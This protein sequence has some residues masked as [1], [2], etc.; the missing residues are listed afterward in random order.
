MTPI[1]T[2]ATVNLEKFPERLR[3]QGASGGLRHRLD[4]YTT[5]LSVC[6]REKLRWLASAVR[7]F[8]AF[9]RIEA[10]WLRRSK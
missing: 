9:G 1:C 3:R 10:S 7:V 8:G 6:G 4:R 5:G 2:N